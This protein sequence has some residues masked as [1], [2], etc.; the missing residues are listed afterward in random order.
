[1]QLMVEPSSGPQLGP[2]L[3]PYLL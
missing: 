2:H 1:M 3:R